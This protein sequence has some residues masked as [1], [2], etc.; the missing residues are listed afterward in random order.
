[1]EDWR[2][3]GIAKRGRGAKKNAKRGDMW[4]MGK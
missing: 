4:E 2:G 3:G 1:M